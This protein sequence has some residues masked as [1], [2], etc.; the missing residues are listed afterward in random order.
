MIFEETSLPGAFLVKSERH[1]DERGRFER[2]WCAAEFASRGLSPKLAQTSL[3]I[4]RQK[5]TLRGLHYQKPP[6]AEDKFVTCLRGRIFDVIVDLRASSPAYGQWLGVELSASEAVALYVPK[7]CAH[8]FVTLE[9]D[10]WLLYQ[11]SE[12]Y[13]PELGSGIRWNDPGLAIAWPIEPAMIS[14][15][16]RA[17]PLFQPGTSGGM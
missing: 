17:L 4:N 7:G 6:A 5:A 11:I 16:D 9:D 8:G 12:F 1:A 10:T 3:S 15:K 14:E 13:A 2:L